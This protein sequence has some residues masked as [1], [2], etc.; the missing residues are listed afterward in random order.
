[1]NTHSALRRLSRWLA[2]VGVITVSAM[3]V[4]AHAA[5]NANSYKVNPNNQIVMEFDAASGYNPIQVTLGL[6]KPLSDGVVIS[7]SQEAGTAVTLNTANPAAPTFLTPSVSAAGAVLRFRATATCPGG[8]SAFDEGTVSVVNVNRPPV[9]YASAS[10]ALADEGAAITLNSTAPGGSPVSNDPDGDSLIY[11][12]TRT[13]GP[14][15]TLAGAN[16]A[17]ASFVAPIT[18]S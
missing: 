4:P 15:V 7:W 2:S 8:S 10:P 6:N 5:C 3:A 11:Q 16:T 9:A 18:G 1:M 12:W 13:A 17:M 14:A